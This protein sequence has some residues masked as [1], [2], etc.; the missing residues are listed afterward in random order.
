M[1]NQLLGIDDKGQLEQ[2]ASFNQ[3][4]VSATRAIQ[5]SY[6]AWLEGSRALDEEVLPLNISRLDQTTRLA[7]E[8]LLKEVS[9]QLMPVVEKGYRLEL[10]HNQHDIT[11][12]LPL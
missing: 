8:A 1:I 4:L 11:A 6:S 9:Q 7:Y 5:P 2:E 12:T 10:T 3:L